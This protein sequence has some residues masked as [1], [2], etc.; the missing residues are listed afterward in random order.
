M[1]DED[2]ALRL[3]NGVGLLNGRAGGFCG[4]RILVPGSR[5]VAGGAGL[6]VDDGAREGSGRACVS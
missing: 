3:T 6:M 4:G 2:D 1:T 5:A